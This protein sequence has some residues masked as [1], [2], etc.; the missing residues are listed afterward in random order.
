MI[1]IFIE[2]VLLFLLPTAVY[3][4]YVMVQRRGAS[5]DAASGD[6]P[7]RGFR[8]HAGEASRAL[9]DAPLLWLF[10]AGAML[11][12][13]TLIAF[14]TSN[15]GKPNEPYEPPSIENGRIVPGHRQ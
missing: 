11:V 5:A 4:I 7:S 15:G 6:S 10:L 1:R 12:V 13:L 14:S 9:D 2:N 3:V 8:R